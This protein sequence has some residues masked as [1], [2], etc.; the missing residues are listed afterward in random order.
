MV[1]KD[2]MDFLA[3][4][5]FLARETHPPIISQKCCS[6]SIWILVYTLDC[7]TPSLYKVTTDYDMVLKWH[8]PNAELQRSNPGTNFNF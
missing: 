1:L 4:D 3:D 2:N 8:K 5:F 7:D 6:V